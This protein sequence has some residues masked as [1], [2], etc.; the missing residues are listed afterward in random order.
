MEFLFNQPYAA[1]TKDTVM[2]RLREHDI[3]AVG[4]ILTADAVVGFVNILALGAMSRTRA[5]C[6]AI[7]V[8]AFVTVFAR[9]GEHTVDAAFTALGI[10]RAAIFL[11]R[12]KLAHELGQG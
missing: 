12:R 10:I 1:K 6:A 3:R 9:R 4:E 2:A 8:G 7:A 11:A 5:A